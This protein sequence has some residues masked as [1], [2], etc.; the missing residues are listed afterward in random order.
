MLL[1]LVCFP[2]G[3]PV[4][5]RENSTYK[6]ETLVYALDGVSLI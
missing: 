3:R 4:F 1:R 2:D 6:L 5:L